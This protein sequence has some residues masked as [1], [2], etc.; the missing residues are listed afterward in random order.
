VTVQLERGS[1][2]IADL[3]GYTHYMSSIDLDAIHVVSELLDTIATEL[4]PYEVVKL[5]GDAVFCQALDGTVG[6]D[7][8]LSLITR[9][10]ERFLEHANRIT[11]D[12]GCGCP[13]CSLLPGLG[14]KFVLHHGEYA[15][16]RIAGLPE[17]VGPEVILVHRLLKNAVGTQWG[18]RDYVLLTEQWA[19][20]LGL[21]SA[22]L[23]GEAHSEAYEHIGTV[24]CRVLNLAGGDGQAG[25]LEAPDASAVST[26][27]T[28]TG[29]DDAATN[30]DAPA[31]VSFRRRTE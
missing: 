24:K 30:A 6:G 26:Q 23:S 18:H 19:Q 9:A 5:E 29:S 8:T 13:A 1:L 22:E 31:P 12:S 17:L 4:T 28:Y 3:S 16:H 15:I 2:L 27:C 7:E 21:E 20:A 14:L 10:Y 25:A 11:D